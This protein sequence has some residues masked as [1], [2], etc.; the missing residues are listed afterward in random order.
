M[1]ENKRKI[2]ICGIVLVALMVTFGIVYFS[3][4]ANET[5][6]PNTLIINIIIIKIDSMH[7]HQIVV[8][9]SLVFAPFRQQ[10]NRN[11]IIFNKFCN[12][13]DDLVSED[14]VV[15]VNNEEIISHRGSVI[16]NEIQAVALIIDI[17]D[18][19]AE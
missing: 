3:K 7:L 5:F 18:A 15:S 6:R 17:D 2:I 9:K 16:L 10:N 12:L 13:I 4:F 11:R 19:V 14:L 8:E 1:K